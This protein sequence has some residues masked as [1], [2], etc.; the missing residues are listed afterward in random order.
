M[1]EIKSYNVKLA[2]DDFGTGY[3]NFEYLLKLDAD[4]IKIDGSMIKNIDTDPNSY[5]VVETIVSFARKNNMKVIAEYVSSQAIQ[6]KV[7]ELG[8][9]FSQGYHIDEPR[10][11][12]DIK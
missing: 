1:D 11:W 7:L 12:E 2:I 3:S 4:Y 8:I 9:D 6:D 5:S 10:F